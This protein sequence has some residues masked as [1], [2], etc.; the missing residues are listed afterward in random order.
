MEL[1]I[2]KSLQPT[3]P[4]RLPRKQPVALHREVF[5]FARARRFRQTLLC[6][7]AVTVAATPE[8]SRLASLFVSSPTPMPEGGIDLAPQVD[9]RF[10]SP[11]GSTLETHYPLG[12]AALEVLIEEAP[13]RL[14]F[15]ALE[16]VV[17]ELKQKEK[18]N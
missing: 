12:K 18:V 9:V 4:V 2:L 5:D 13:R 15:D 17:Q 10:E 14:S 1:T 6:R 16:A 7:T 3:Q 8:P 11:R